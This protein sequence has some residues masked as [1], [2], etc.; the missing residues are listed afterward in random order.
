MALGADT[1][2]V[3]AADDSPY[4]REGFSCSGPARR[5]VLSTELA[6]TGTYLWPWL[7]LVRIWV[8]GRW[9]E[10]MV[11]VIRQ[12]QT[13][14]CYVGVSTRRRIDRG[15]GVPE[16]SAGGGRPT[17]LV[18]EFGDVGQGSRR[19]GEQAAAVLWWW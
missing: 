7:L 3:N 6:G 4:E 8:F 10:V 14:G 1:A 17:K 18:M 5:V 9:P 12:I 13:T 16:G 19:R 15:S 2:V 11:A